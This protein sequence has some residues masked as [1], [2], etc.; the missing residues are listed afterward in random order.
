MPQVHAAVPDL[1]DID[2]FM[3]AGLSRGC[4]CVRCVGDV[5]GAEDEHRCAPA[6][7]LGAAGVIVSHSESSR[8][9]GCLN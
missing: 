4:R 1:F 7:G 2:Q 3:N 5:Q 9:S 6:L 8:P